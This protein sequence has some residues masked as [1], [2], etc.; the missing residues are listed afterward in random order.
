M[1]RYILVFSFA[2][3]I[4]I[5][6]SSFTDTEKRYMSEQGKSVVDVLKEIRTTQG[7]STNERIDPNKV[8]PLLLDELGD[9]VM[10]VM[11]P[12]PREHEWMDNM[13]GGEGSASLS[14]MHQQTGY[15]Y[16]TGQGF[17]MMGG[18]ME[19]WRGGPYGY[20]RGHMG[21]GM[22]G[23]PFSSWGRGGFG[24]MNYG[25]GGAILMW[26]ILI[27]LI[28]FIVWLVVRSQRLKENSG[29]GYRGEKP[30]EIIKRRYAR[31]EISREEFEQLRKDLE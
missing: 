24:M 17:P 23:Y 28:V 2:L 9:A 15:R 5:P 13:M 29:S 10:N 19:P 14:A 1:K 4:L 30:V 27:A 22:M 18:W 16:L 7:I 6:V 31:G 11:V 25:F 12:D 21:G 8:S 3:F 26:I 20:R